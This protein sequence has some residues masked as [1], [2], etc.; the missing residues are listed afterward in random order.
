M[1]IYPYHK[2]EVPYEHAELRLK[3]LIDILKP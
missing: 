1:E 3:T 2:H